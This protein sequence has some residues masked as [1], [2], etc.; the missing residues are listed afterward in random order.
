MVFSIKKLLFIGSVAFGI[1][2]HIIAMESQSSKTIGSIKKTK[3]NKKARTKAQQIY[4][5]EKYQKIRNDAQPSIEDNL[6]K[7]YVAADNI[8]WNITPSKNLCWD[9]IS[10]KKKH[11]HAT[12]G[13]TYHI[14]G[15]IY[16]KENNDIA[17]MKRLH[18]HMKILAPI[19]HLQISM[20][21][22]SK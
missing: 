6:L 22:E 12:M 20:R 3:A 19:L 18:M 1:P 14:L 17:A 11:T 5:D 21:K 16:E 10:N 15:S 8:F 2:Y 9:I 4:R 13:S 7:S